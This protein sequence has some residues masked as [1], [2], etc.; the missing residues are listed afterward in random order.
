VIVC[1]HYNCGGVRAAMIPRDMG[2][3]NPWLRNIR[4][5]YRFHE[6]E[7][8]AIADEGGRYGRLV[9]LNVQEQCINVIKTAAL[10]VSYQE[11]GYP[12]V[13]GW[14]L[15]VRERRSMDRTL[16]HEG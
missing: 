12:I 4:D 5:I 3:L 9:E 10:Q 8:D 15:A 1:G 11:H 13:P 14:V 7:L 16:D 6:A 2:I